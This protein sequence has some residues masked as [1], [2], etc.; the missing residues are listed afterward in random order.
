MLVQEIYNKHINPMH[1]DIT[2]QEALKI[3]IEKDFNSVLVVNKHEKLVGVLSLQ[4]I[5]TSIIPVEMK[6]NP[7]LA[8]AMYKT[9]FFHEAAQEIKDKPIKKFMR[10]NFH[11]VSPQTN[12]MEV[13]AEFLAND[14]YIVPVCEKEKL[15]GIITRSDIRHAFALAME[16]EI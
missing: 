10:T 5:A 15:V 16:I 12:V 6:E 2:I 4:D 13:A 7:N 8:E 1:E 9:H 11:C 14:L 3:F